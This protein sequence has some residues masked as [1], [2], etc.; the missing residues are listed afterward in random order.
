MNIAHPPTSRLKAS[1]ICSSITLNAVKTT[2][3]LNVPLS[4][5]YKNIILE[6]QTRPI[7][8]GRIICRD[9]NIVTVQYYLQ[10]ILY[11][12]QKFCEQRSRRKM[13]FYKCNNVKINTDRLGR[14]PGRAQYCQCLVIIIYI[15]VSTHVR[16]SNKQSSYMF[17]PNCLVHH[18]YKIYEVKP[19]SEHYGIHASKERTTGWLRPWLDSVKTS[20]RRNKAVSKEKVVITGNVATHHNQDT[21]A[22]I[23]ENRLKRIFGGFEPTPEVVNRSRPVTLPLCQ[24]A[25]TIQ[26]L[27][28]NSTRLIADSQHNQ[29]PSQRHGEHR[30]RTSN[31]GHR[32]NKRKKNILA[33][34]GI[35]PG[36]PTQK[37]RMLAVCHT[38][39]SKKT[40]LTLST[41]QKAVGILIIK[42][43][44]KPI[45]DK[46]SQHANIEA[47]ADTT[48][49]LSKNRNMWHKYK[50]CRGK[51][52]SYW[53]VTK[54][55]YSTTKT[56]PGN[57]RPTTPADITTSKAPKS[58]TR[59]KYLLAVRPQ[60]PGPLFRQN[61]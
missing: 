32:I 8:N 6:N 45:L 34:T 25:I 48:G 5:R 57:K 27:I 20:F 23:Y 28:L 14:P 15:Y 3:I 13:A 38:S 4:S 50:M 51:T 24:A 37:T 47:T 56:K 2:L 36:T 42:R 44:T 29:V 12:L 10:I 33:T 52:D 43:K 59:Q 9:K 18:C 49:Q 11:T 46:A 7:K 61:G 53:S 41:Y 58:H 39:S 31:Q 22:N 54:C 30:R 60:G 19:S 16:M 26:N 55:H 21:L 1:N 35:E 40:M 17:K